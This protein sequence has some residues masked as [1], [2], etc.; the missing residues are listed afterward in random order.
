ML[1]TQTERH[2]RHYYIKYSAGICR[3]E[4][5]IRK[6]AQFYGY[7]RRHKRVQI[8]FFVLLLREFLF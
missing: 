7:I 4:V 8:L 2:K 3:I 6:I 1:K 5:Y